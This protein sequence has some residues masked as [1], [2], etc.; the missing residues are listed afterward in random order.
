MWTVSSLPAE[1]TKRWKYRKE[2][3]RLCV[4]YVMYLG[5]SCYWECHA[6]WYV[7]YL[8]MSCIWV[9]HVFGYV[10]KCSN[11]VVFFIV[12]FI[13]KLCYGQLVCKW[14]I[15]KIRNI[16]KNWTFKWTSYIFKIRSWNAFFY[17]GNSHFKM[18]II[19]QKCDKL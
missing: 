19:L 11:R 14:R 17:E 16:L 9:C 12:Q 1:G 6:L 8:G 7:M 4:W 10:M 13:Y 18:T 15:P 5:M 2:M 3:E